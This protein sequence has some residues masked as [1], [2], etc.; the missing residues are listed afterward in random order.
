MKAEFERTIEFTPK[1]EDTEDP[2][3]VRQADFYRR[4][5]LIKGGLEKA[6]LADDPQGIEDHLLWLTE[7]GGQILEN[8][9]N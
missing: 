2:Y 7:I 3:W 5:N 1:I 9:L 4:L 6:Q 8:N